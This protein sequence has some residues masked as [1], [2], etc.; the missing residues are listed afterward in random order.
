MATENGTNRVDEFTREAQDTLERL[1][2]QLS[3]GADAARTGLARQLREAA[4]RI[5]EEMAKEEVNDE[6]REQATRVLER[7]DGAAEFLE[8]HT[9]QTMEAEA[10]EAV[11]ER[12][13]QALLIAF[14]VGLVIG[15]LVARD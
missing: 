5:R 1:G 13:W 10:R 11:Q 6:A 7:L 3:R 14:I 12:P 2:D 8:T 15:I 4:T 9:I